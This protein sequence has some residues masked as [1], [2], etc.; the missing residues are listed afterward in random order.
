MPVVGPYASEA[1]KSHINF[2]HSKTW[3][4]PMYLDEKL[5]DADGLGIAFT[6]T[7]IIAVRMG[8]ILFND[9]VENLS[10]SYMGLNLNS[11]KKHY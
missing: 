9:L 10:L 5:F 4:P 2:T 7:V 3:F 6:H 11:R 1:S 8:L